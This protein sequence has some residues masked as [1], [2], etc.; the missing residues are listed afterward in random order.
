MIA[1]THNPQHTL[2]TVERMA[3]ARIATAPPLRQTKRQQ[4]QSD[5]GKE[6]F[7]GKFIMWIGIFIV[8]MRPSTLLACGLYIFFPFF[9]SFQVSISFSLRFSFYTPFKNASISR[10]DIIYTNGP[11]NSKRKHTLTKHSHWFQTKRGLVKNSFSFRYQTPNNRKM[12]LR[13]SGFQIKTHTERHRHIHT[14]THTDIK[15]LNGKE[16]TWKSK[17]SNKRERKEMGR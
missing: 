4:R 9:I 8:D 7:E 17:N 6:P 16:V 10:L 2:V 12:L 1:M 11:S 5:D 3:V 13:L 15:I 14:R